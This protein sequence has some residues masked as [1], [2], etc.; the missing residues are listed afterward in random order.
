[1][2]DLTRLVVDLTS[3]VIDLTSLVIELTSLVIDLTSLVIDL[4][5]LV[6]DLTSY[7]I[8]ITSL[9]VELT[10]LVI[11][12]ASDE[13]DLPSSVTPVRGLETPP[14]REWRYRST[15]VSVRGRNGTLAL[16]RAGWK[17]AWRGSSRSRTYVRMRSAAPRSSITPSAHS[18]IT[19]PTTACT[20][21]SRPRSHT[22]QASPGS[23][24][25]MR[26]A[27]ECDSRAACR[28]S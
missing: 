28:T 3:L 12:I 6:V 16:A 2:I 13:L 15:S 27:R 23:T 18:R 22:K 21:S 8:S 4:T 5:S 17:N 24:R 25:P 10:S 20:S 7:V 19:P 14:A 11:S 26:T 9:V 1:V